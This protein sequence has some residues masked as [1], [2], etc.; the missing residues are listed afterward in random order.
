MAFKDQ[1]QHYFDTIEEMIDLLEAGQ[2][3]KAAQRT[4]MLLKL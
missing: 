2:L 4:E 1:T 3:H